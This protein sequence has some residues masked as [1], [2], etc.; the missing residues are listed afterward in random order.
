[1]KSDNQCIVGKKITKI[2]DELGLNNVKFS[3]KCGID[4]SSLGKIVMGKLGISLE[5]ALKIS[6]AC[7]VDLRWLVDDDIKLEDLPTYSIVNPWLTEAYNNLLESYSTQVKVN[8]EQ[9]V[10]IRNLLNSDA[11]E[12]SQLKQPA[13]ALFDKIFSSQSL[14]DISNA[15]DEDL[16]KLGR[17]IEEFF[18]NV[19]KE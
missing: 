14:M 12:E 6:K 18:L 15:T 7:N 9:F 8:F 13:P 19:K 17:L 4:N 10:I 1:M 3:K 16:K 11:L 2:Q 5:I